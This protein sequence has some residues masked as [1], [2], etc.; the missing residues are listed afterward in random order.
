MAG[1]TAP[2]HQTGAVMTRCDIDKGGQVAGATVTVVGIDRLQLQMA[3][4]ALSA[5]DGTGG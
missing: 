1:I 5:E 4:G 2:T 3:A